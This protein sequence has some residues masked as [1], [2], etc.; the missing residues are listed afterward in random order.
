M[1]AA[2]GNIHPLAP[3]V[4]ARRQAIKTL[5]AVASAEAHGTV[6]NL[7]KAEVPRRQARRPEKVPAQSVGGRRHQ[8]D[9]AVAAQ[10]PPGQAD[11]QRALTCRAHI[12]ALSCRRWQPRH[13]CGHLR[14]KRRRR[15][16]ACRWRRVPIDALLAACHIVPNLHSFRHRLQQTKRSFLRCQIIQRI[17]VASRLVP[18]YSNRNR[19]GVHAKLH[20]GFVPSYGDAKVSGQLL[21]ELLHGPGRQLGKCAVERGV[22]DVVAGKWIGPFCE[23]EQWVLQVTEDHRRILLTLQ[24]L[25]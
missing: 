17:A 14:C 7:G 25:A 15:T 12:G 1:L 10:G 11:V 8:V 22:G 16:H 5:T 23:I 24:G 2:V 13:S 20:R 18:I 6:D 4:R 19:T 9:A 3:L 21:A